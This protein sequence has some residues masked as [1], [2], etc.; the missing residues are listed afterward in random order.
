MG[1]RVIG[2]EVSGRWEPDPVGHDKEFGF[3]SGHD[4]IA[5]EKFE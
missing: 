2:D 4:W 3:Y 1:R 5:P